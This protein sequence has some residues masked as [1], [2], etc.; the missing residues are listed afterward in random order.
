[1]SVRALMHI[2]YFTHINESERALIQ[3]ERSSRSAKEAYFVPSSF[4]KIPL[5]ASDNPVQ[6]V[7]RVA[8]P[9]LTTRF[10]HKST[11]LLLYCS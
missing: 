4:T 11:Q 9:I 3:Q 5:D 6:T 7:W 10:H 2:N 8:C 1:M